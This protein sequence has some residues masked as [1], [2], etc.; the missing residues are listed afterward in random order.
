MKSCIY[1]GNV[2]SDNDIRCPYCGREQS[3]DRSRRRD[4]AQNAESAQGRPSEPKEDSLYT[5][6]P[7]APD[8]TIMFDPH[9]V[10]NPQTQRQAPYSNDIY[11]NRSDCNED[12][13]YDDYSDRFD[14]RSEQRNPDGQGKKDPN[15][16]FIIGMSIAGAVILILIL[17]LID[18]LGWIRGGSVDP[19]VE[20]TTMPSVTETQATSTPIT[21]APPLTEPSTQ[22]STAAT[23]PSA[24]EEA[25]DEEITT[26]APIVISSP[27]AG[28]WMT[29]V[30]VGGSKTAEDICTFRSD[31]TMN[32]T[33]SDAEISIE[34]T[35][36]VD[37]DKLTTS[38]SL[39][40]NK[41]NCTYTY[42]I[43]GD[44]LTV[45]DSHGNQIVFIK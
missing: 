25:P 11:S 35:Y 9:E 3:V 23:E 2:I 19:T 27:V 13:D 32:V 7:T 45:T 24:T 38:V 34:G 4:S 18:P 1:C 17:L 36:T 10:T 21:S 33:I 40:G 5:R 39:L 28:Q 29:N 6:R 43:D 26:E 37:G 41:G 42:S 15:K 8:E 30:M 14:R 31:G 44:K 12:A 22:A 16:P 20:S